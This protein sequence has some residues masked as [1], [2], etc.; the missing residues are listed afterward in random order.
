MRVKLKIDAEQVRRAIEVSEKGGTTVRRGFQQGTLFQRG[1]RRKLWVARWWEDVIKPNG[2]LGRLRRSE[3]IGTIAEYP[4]RR[5]AMQVLSQKLRALNRGE[6]R[7]QSTLTFADF[8]R[9]EWMPVILPTLK[10]AT[11][12]HYHYVL[13]SHLLPAFGKSQLRNLTREDL[14]EFLSRKINGG[15]SWETVHPSSVVSARFSE[16]P[17]SGDISTI[18]LPGRRNSRDGIMERSG[19]CLP[20]FKC[21]TSPANYTSHSERSCCCWC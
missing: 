8:V 21:K 3:V 12:K 16:Q 1:T 15:L 18:I 17:K 13:D 9:N 10:Y 4:T 2:A 20:R 14:Q 11:Q 5:Q 6:A 19:R 7:P